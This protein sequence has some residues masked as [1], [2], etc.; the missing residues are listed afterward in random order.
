MKIYRLIIR[1]LGSLA[2]IGYVLFLIGEK[3]TFFKDATFADV[4]VY[5]LFAIFL[6]GYIFLWNFELISGIILIVWYGI[7]WGL[8]FWVWEDGEMTLIFG[9][10]I[11]IIGILVLIYG[12]RKRSN[13]SS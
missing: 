11:A 1:I 12:I 7:Q 13:T 8:V 2:L 10:P 5:L 9:F 6:V 4:T 3:V